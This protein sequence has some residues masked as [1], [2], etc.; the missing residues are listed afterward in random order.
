MIL[1]ESTNERALVSSLK[2]CDDRN[3]RFDWLTDSL[4]QLNSTQYLQ[5]QGRAH[6]IVM[7]ILLEM[8][9]GFGIYT[10]ASASATATAAAA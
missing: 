6:A 8:K 1:A 9:R 5:L 10:A 7:M 2:S 3:T 4:R